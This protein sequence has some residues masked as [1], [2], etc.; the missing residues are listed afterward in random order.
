MRNEDNAVQ[1]TREQ[2][3]LKAVEEGRDADLLVLIQFT[4]SVD[5]MSPVMRVRFRYI[6]LTYMREVGI[7]EQVLASRHPMF[8]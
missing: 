5:L 7:H 6:G 4:F 1:A 3:M 2:R 8:G